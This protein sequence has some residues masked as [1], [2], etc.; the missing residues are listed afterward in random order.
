M[1]RNQ[2]QPGSKSGGGAAAEE[3]PVSRV[4]FGYQATCT[5][6]PGYAF[7]TAALL[8]RVPAGT[9]VC[10]CTGMQ[11][12]TSYGYRT[13]LAPSTIPTSRV[14]PVLRLDRRK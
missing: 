1:S 6:V 11:Q 12:V 9:R 3:S 14:G 7:Q 13:P 5:S 4:V 2:P 8:T 10:T